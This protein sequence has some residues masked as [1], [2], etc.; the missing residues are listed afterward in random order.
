M[1]WNKKGVRGFQGF[2]LFLWYLIGIDIIN[3]IIFNIIWVKFHCN[4][5][6][7]NIYQMPYILP[8]RIGRIAGLNDRWRGVN[9]VVPRLCRLG[10]YPWQVLPRQTGSVPPA[11]DWTSVN[12]SEIWWSLG[13][14]ARWMWLMQ[15][16]NH[17]LKINGVYHKMVGGR[18]TTESANGQD[19]PVQSANYCSHL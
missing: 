10:F 17:I 15:Q 12:F 3:I 7:Y 1:N 5:I 13:I 16:M 4:D 11:N 14:G 8:Y 19:H 18:A 2:H 9:G 6:W